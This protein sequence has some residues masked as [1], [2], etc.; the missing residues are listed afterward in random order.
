MSL[1]LILRSTSTQ[2]IDHG[3]PKKVLGTFR[4]VKGATFFNALCFIPNRHGKCTTCDK[5]DQPCVFWR[6]N[7]PKTLQKWLSWQRSRIGNRGIDG[8]PGSSLS[9]SNEVGLPTTAYSNL[10]NHCKSRTVSGTDRTIWRIAA[11]QGWKTGCI[12]CNASN[13]Q[14]T[15]PGKTKYLCDPC[16]LRG[17]TDCAIERE[18]PTKK[19]VGSLSRQRRAAMS[20]VIR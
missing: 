17:K 10:P 4:D 1:T 2:F 18:S 20:H 13:T 12:S 14:C 7:P 8:N 5:A 15:Y 11:G 16:L 9:G 6:K 3:D 19:S